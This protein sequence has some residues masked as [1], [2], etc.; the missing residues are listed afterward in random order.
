MTARHPVHIDLSDDSHSERSEHSEHA[1]EEEEEGTDDSEGAGLLD[2][3]AVEDDDDSDDSDAAYGWNTTTNRTVER[4]HQ[5][6]KLPVELR[7]HIWS[8]FCPDLTPVPRILIFFTDISGD[9]RRW[10]IDV[11]YGLV[12]VTRPRRRMMAT[13][14]ETRA[15][16][17][18]RFPDT[19]KFRETGFAYESIVPFNRETDIVYLDL[20]VASER[21]M[22]FMDAGALLPG[23]SDQI[24]HLALECTAFSL[25]EN[26]LGPPASPLF[27]HQNFLLCFPA[28]RTFYAVVEAEAIG[29]ST[30]LWALSD[31]AD[32]LDIPMDESEYGQVEYFSY[33]WHKPDT[34]C[35]LKG[36]CSAL[37]D[38]SMDDRAVTRLIQDVEE[39]LEFDG[40]PVSLEGLKHVQQLPM[41]LFVEDARE[42]KLKRRYHTTVAGGEVSDDTEWDSVDEVESSAS[43]D[44]PADDLNVPP[45]EA[46][47]DESGDEPGEDADQVDWDAYESEGIDDASI[48]EPETDDDGESSEVSGY[49][50]GMDDAPGYYYDDR[51]HGFSPLQSGDESDGT[52]GGPGNSDGGPEGDDLEDD[53][54][55]M[56]RSR[57]LATRPVVVDDSDDECD[58]IMEKEDD[59]A[60]E[61]LED[62]APATSRSRRTAKRR[63]VV[64]D[65]DD[66]DGE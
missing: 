44:S 19:L 35:K 57:R 6:Q 37:R 9:Q 56:A 17:L 11:T 21:N 40:R 5:F 32:H 49:G 41:L 27:L 15:M 23:F 48:P 24:A 47:A 62:T 51:N 63:F 64:D 12:E 59:N 7:H 22:P 65:S 66:G 38:G 36:F 39:S 28:L 58:K 34:S 1:E 13:H 18:R 42:E 4:F 20:G 2:L 43:D 60:D 31:H 54:P 61:Q 30:A 14:R 29:I 52:M 46:S 8:F 26:L 50:R 10:N 25:P 16:A 55:A 53:V 45:S 3:E 33:R